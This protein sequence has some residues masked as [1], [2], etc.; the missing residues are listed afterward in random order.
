M[1]KQQLSDAT[2]RATKPTVKD[3]RLFDGNGLYLLIKPNDSRWWRL[4]YSINRTRKTLSLGTYPL[5]SLADARKKAYE[6]KKLVIS[7]V[8]P[9]EVRKAAKEEG[10]KTQ[11]DHQRISNGLPPID[12]FKY[13]ADEWY[14]K[15]MQ[16]MAESYKGRVYSQLERDVF[17]QIGN[18]KL[19]EVTP[20]QL[21][22]IV[23][24]IENRGAVE[25]AHRTLRTCSQIFRYGI[26]TGR[27]SI[28][29]TVSL[30]GALSSVKSGHFSAITDIKKFKEL[31][32]AIKYFSGSRIVRAAL[33]IAPHVFVRPGELRAAK[34]SDI[35]FEAKEWRYLV[36]KRL[37]CINRLLAPCCKE[38]H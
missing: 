16:H 2:I 12:S 35:D 21:L 22:K 4:D 5:T 25:S 6:L 8:D 29:A 31:L 1:A 11:L 26:V 10:V 13:V 7:G 3:V 28:D 37:C 19:T 38:I 33:Q 18:K 9:S 17:P 32:T 23:Q 27:V 14:S 34:W 20:Q 30:K 36:T 24:E 15:K